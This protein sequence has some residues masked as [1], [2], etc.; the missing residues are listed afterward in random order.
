M[1]IKSVH[2]WPKDQSPQL[3]LDVIL[4][5]HLHC[6]QKHETPPSVW[7]SA[8]KAY[9][10]AEL[11]L[12]RRQSIEATAY[13]IRLPTSKPQAEATPLLPT[14]KKREKKE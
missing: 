13:F 3:S 5:Q 2:R 9:S 10:K 11:M 7:V 14:L 12:E 6:S 4:K 1:L 8:G